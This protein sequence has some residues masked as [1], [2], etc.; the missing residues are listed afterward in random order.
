MWHVITEED[1][2]CTE[3]PH[4]IPRGALCLSQMPPLMPDDFKRKKYEN[5]CIDC[6]ECDAGKPSCYARRL[7]HWHTRDVTRESLA[8]AHC[9]LTIPRWTWTASQKI[10]AWP[11][12]EMDSDS[13][14]GSDHFYGA[15]PGVSTG[16]SLRPQPADWH[17]LSPE[18]QR[19]FQRGGLG[20]GLGIRSRKMAQRLYEKEVPAPVRNMGEAAVKDFLDGKDFSHIR[21]VANDPSMAKAPSN[22]ILEDAGKNRARGS[23]NM[24]KADRAAANQARRPSG[25][26][27]GGKAALKGGSKAGIISAALEAVVSIPEN[28]LHYRRG[29]KSRQQAAKDAGFD[30]AKAGA[31][32][33]GVWG[34]STGA[35]AIGVGIPLGPFGVPLQIAGVTLIAGTAAYR[36][37]KAWQH[38][39]PLD[40]YRIFFCKDTDC[41][42]QFAENL[43]RI[44]E[45]SADPKFPWLTK[46]VTIGLAAVTV[47]AISGLVAWSLLT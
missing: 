8:C 35:Q 24:P 26:R 1:I 31:F 22:V 38:D 45:E 32:G 20:R 40:E 18:M 34:L 28:I 13:D 23:A 15:A 46:A 10:Y 39:L 29:R 25:F 30:T 27:A 21:S 3:C 44:P 36:I 17:N 47:L 2:K 6:T 19:R 43:S 12:P 5:F 11:Q 37:H 42:D 4:T 7:N 14:H 33:V 16:A 41:K 9:G